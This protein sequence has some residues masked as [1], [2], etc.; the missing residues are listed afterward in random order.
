[1]RSYYCRLNENSGQGTT[2]VF[3]NDYVLQV[4]DD[5]TV[6]ENVCFS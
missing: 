2:L 3:G 1:M 4:H 5:S 6:I